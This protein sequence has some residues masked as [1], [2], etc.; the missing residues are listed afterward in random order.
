MSY[1]ILDYVP[2]SHNRYPHIVMDNIRKTAHIQSYHVFR[3]RNITA[4]E[5]RDKHRSVCSSSYRHRFWLLHIFGKE[6]TKLGI[7]LNLLNQLCICRIFTV[8]WSFRILCVLE[9]DQR[10]VCAISAHKVSSI[11]VLR[12]RPE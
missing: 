10:I 4:R 11:F 6:Y 12:S 1:N 9:R 7:H 3:H 5:N 2:R 8:L